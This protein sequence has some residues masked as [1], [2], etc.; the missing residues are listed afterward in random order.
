MGVQYTE[1]QNSEPILGSLT[2][3]FLNGFLMFL[4]HRL[5]PKRK[6]SKEAMHQHGGKRISWLQEPAPA[7]DE[8]L[9]GLF[10]QLQSWRIYF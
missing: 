4:Q 7:R 8:T 2:L 1:A 5:A 9:Q 3:C 10:G 6:P